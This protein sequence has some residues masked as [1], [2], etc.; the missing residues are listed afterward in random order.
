MDEVAVQLPLKEAHPGPLQLEVK[1]YGTVTAQTIP[2]RAYAAA[3]HLD[4]FTLHAGDAQGMLKGSTLEDV[5]NLTLDGVT[6]TPGKIDPTM[7][8]DELPMV[9]KEAKDA[10]KLKQ[11]ESSKAQVTL[12]DGRAM[13]VDVAVGAP[14]PGVDADRQERAGFGVEHGQQYPAGEPGRTAAGCE[15]DVQRAGAV[16]GDLPARGAN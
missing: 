1:Q 10:A 14:R 12:T 13:T 9:A 6:F 15:A 3:G 7:G 2:L 11:G 16:A 4:S 8:S 5:A